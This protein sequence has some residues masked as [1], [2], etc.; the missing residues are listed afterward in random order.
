M[1]C[2]TAG[3][4][5]QRCATGVDRGGEQTGP[6]LEDGRPFEAVALQFDPAAALDLLGSLNALASGNGAG[7][8]VLLWQKLARFVIHFVG[9]RQFAPHIDD[10]SDGVATAGW[11]LSI[12]DPAHIAWLERLAAAMPRVCLA[13][14]RTDGVATDSGYLIETFLAA[15]TDALIRR[16]VA[17]DPFFQRAQSGPRRRR[18]RRNCFGYRLCLRGSDA[19]GG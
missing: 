15:T 5:F 14:G 18:P 17:D 16:C 19:Q 12:Q 1:S 9:A 11:R 4:A 7:T 2:A 8:S 6:A 13:I 10:S 3:R